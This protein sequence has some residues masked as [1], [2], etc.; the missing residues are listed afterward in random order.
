VI[1]QAPTVR[2]AL[3]GMAKS[4]A[5]EQNRK[6]GAADQGERVTDAGRKGERRRSG[7]RAT[8]ATGPIR[9]DLAWR[10]KG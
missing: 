9:G 10:L 1:R 7:W 4:R 5:D 2:G 8:K 3:E 6:R